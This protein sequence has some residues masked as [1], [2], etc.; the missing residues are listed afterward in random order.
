M[1]LKNLEIVRFETKSDR[2]YYWIKYPEEIKKILN[3]LNEDE[4][5]GKQSYA[6]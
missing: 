5:N 2:S 3:A 6:C 1:Q 4:S